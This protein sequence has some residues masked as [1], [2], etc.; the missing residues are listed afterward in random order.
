MIAIPIVAVMVAVVLMLTLS[1]N[2]VTVPDAVGKTSE[3]ANKIFADSGLRTDTVYEYSAE[4]PADTVI[5][6]SAAAGSGVSRGSTVTLTVSKGAEQVKVPDLLGKTADEAYDTL[7]D[8]GFAYK[9][10]YEYSELF[11]KGTVSGQNVEGGKTADKGSELILVISNGI[12]LV[13]VPEL[14]GKTVEE[15]EKLAK[16]A[17]FALYTELKCNSS[18]KEGLLYSQDVKAGSTI[19]RNGTVKAL[20]S[21]GKGGNTVGNSCANSLCHG[22]VTSQG[23]WIY[24]VDHGGDHDLYRVKKDGSE[25]Q[26]VTSGSVTSIN[27]VDEWIYFHRES[28]TKGLYRIRLDGTGETLLA[29]GTYYWVQVSGDKIYYAPFS[30]NGPLYRMNTDGSEPRQIGGTECSNVNI[31]GDTVYYLNTVDRFIYKMRTDGSGKQLVSDEVRN[32]SNLTLLDGYLYVTGNYSIYKVNPKNGSVQQFKEDDRQKMYINSYDGTLYFY[33]V[34]LSDGAL[35]YSICRMQPDGMKKSTVLSNIT[36]PEANIYLNVSDGWI[37]F[38]NG[39]DNNRMYKIK[40][41]GALLQRAL[42]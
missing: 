42:K 15:A 23:D 7:T 16:E 21:G 26:L 38:P 9:I 10:L 2:I 18:V 17:G 27:V 35:T 32:P 41:S 34:D 8:L 25:K 31:S 30:Q 5:S 29:T 24:L 40:T 39:A 12:D 3:A 14:S 36:L 37:Y 11:E 6:Q 19:R 1:G 20:V 22:N 13:A 33:E 4:H 28:G